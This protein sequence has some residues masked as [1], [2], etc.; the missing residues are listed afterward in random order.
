MDDGVET[1]E[2]QGSPREEETVPLI[3]LASAPR[4]GC[5][6]PPFSKNIHKISPLPAREPVQGA[7][8]Y[9]SALSSVSEPWPSSCPGA[10]ETALRQQFPAYV[11]EKGRLVG[12]ALGQLR[13]DDPC[14][15]RHVIGKAWTCKMA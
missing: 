7:D 1:G 4:T 3:Y 12:L 2:G 10:T 6:P 11:G 14:G 9:Y 13:Q 5:N 15:L 8:A